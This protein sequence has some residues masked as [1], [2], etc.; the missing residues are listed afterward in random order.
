[1]KNHRNGECQCTLVQFRG[2]ESGAGRCPPHKGVPNTLVL[3]GLE[4]VALRFM[5]LERHI[6]DMK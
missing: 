5:P 4:F 3:Q 6:G 1:M 2:R